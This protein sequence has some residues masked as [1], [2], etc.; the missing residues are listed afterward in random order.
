MNGHAAGR[1]VLAGSGLLVYGLQLPGGWLLW[2]FGCGVS[3]LTS[4]ARE[5]KCNRGVL[6]ISSVKYE[7][8]FT[9]F[10]PT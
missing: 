3:L 4:R 2:V 8:S 5:R 6:K 1:S 10:K 9:L 7:K